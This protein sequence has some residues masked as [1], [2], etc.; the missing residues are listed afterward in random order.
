MAS[1]TFRVGDSSGEVV[2][3]STPLQVDVTI[4]E[5]D[6]NNDNVFDSLQVDL[7]VV[8]GFTAD[9]RGFFFNVEDDNLLNNLTVTGED[10]TGDEYDTDGDGIPEISDAAPPPPEAQ[11]DP[12]AFD[13]GIELGTPGTSTDD[14]DST[15]FVISSTNGTNL[16]LSLLAGESIGIRAQS[17]GEDRGG[18][19]KLTEDVPPSPPPPPPP[20]PSG[21]QP[22]VS[23][24]KE[25]DV[26]FDFELSSDV[27]INLDKDVMVDVNVASDIDLDG[28]VA[29]AT[30]SAEAIGTDTFAEADVHVLAVE[31]KLSSIDGVLVAAAG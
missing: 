10:V 12:L 27:D 21:E 20:P 24:E 5:I 13:A 9:L 28:N 23:F 18:S 7:D 1:T 16:D 22:N 31:D 17:V 25:L 14:I 26:S 3:G 2:S 8:N 30:F 6:T 11:I 19:S 4:T 15:T 29:Q